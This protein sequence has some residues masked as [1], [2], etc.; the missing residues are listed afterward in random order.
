MKNLQKEIDY[1]ASICGE[2]GKSRVAIKLGE[3]RDRLQKS[4]TTLQEAVD[5]LKEALKDDSKLD[6]AWRYINKNL[7][8]VVKNLSSVKKQLK[9]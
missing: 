8:A 3:V 5:G 2:G 9:I 1:L 7:P 6:D 4:A